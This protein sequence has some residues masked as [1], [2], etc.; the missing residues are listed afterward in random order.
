MARYTIAKLKTNFG[1]KKS[2]LELANPLQY[3]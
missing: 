2:N 3:R 1:T